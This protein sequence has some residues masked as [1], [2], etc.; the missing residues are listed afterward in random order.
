MKHENFDT[1]YPVTIPQ[2]STLRD[3]KS[4]PRRTIIAMIHA[5]YRS[6]AKRIANLND[7]AQTRYE[8]GQLSDRQLKDIGVNRSDLK[9]DLG[10]LIKNR[11]TWH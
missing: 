11:A 6:C 9:V 4:K 7:Q 8:L 5:F 10:P 2:I 3:S 1:F